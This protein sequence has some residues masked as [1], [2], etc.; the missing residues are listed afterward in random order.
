MTAAVKILGVCFVII[1][2]AA[3]GFLES[4]KLS[5]RVHILEAL[6]AVFEQIRSEVLF[7]SVPVGQLLPEVA[8][9]CQSEEVQRFL[10]GVDAQEEDLFSERWQQ[11]LNQHAK[12]LLLEKDPFYALC[13]V[14][15]YLGK[16]D[17]KEQD[18]SLT[19]TIDRLQQ[20]LTQARPERDKKSKLYRTLGI[21]AG[22]MSVIF[23]L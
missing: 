1:G 3:I 20:A 18:R 13:N 7:L 17:I 16:Y 9:R 14:G 15:S 4:H 21:T 5:R 23:L 19:K 12:A 11:A 22:V 8:G 10:H 6:V 2:A